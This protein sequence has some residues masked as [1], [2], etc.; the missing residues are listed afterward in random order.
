M[1][2]C[3]L[4]VILALAVLVFPVAA[5]ADNTLTW[6][7]TGGTF[8]AS[9]MGMSISGSTIVAVAYPNG[10]DPMG[11]NLGTL[12][13]TTGAL[14]SGNLA[15]GC[16]ASNGGCSFAFSGSSFTITGTKGGEAYTGS[17]S[18]N[19]TLSGY[20]TANGTYQYTISGGMLAG[21]VGGNS[22]MTPGTTTQLTIYLNHKFTGGSVNLAGGTTTA[23]VP[24]PGTLGLLGT[25]LFGLAGV[26][27]RRM[28]Q[29]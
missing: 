20:K 22:M 19:I 28:V 6:H 14:L 29:S 3:K 1:K 16:L 8:A 10:K 9:A 25:G 18:E 12:S 4:V 23:A 21:N 11:K 5:M 7:N 17:F 24:E 26:L 15:S 27:K 13:L 2:Y